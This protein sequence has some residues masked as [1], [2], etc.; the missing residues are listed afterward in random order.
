MFGYVKIVEDELLVRQQKLYKNCYCALCKQIGCYSQFSRLFLS[1]DMTFWALLED[2]VIPDL[3][4]HC[5]G[6]WHR[7]CK[8][9][10]GD[11]KMK[12]CAAISIMLQ[13]QKLNDDVIDGKKSRRIIRRAI[14]KGFLRAK[15]DYPGTEALI[16]AAMEELLGLEKEQCTDFERLETSFCSIFERMLLEAPYSDSY[17]TIKAEI[18]YHV[19][20]WVYLFDMLQD[21]E[22][23][24][25]TGNFNVL[26]IKEETKTRE[27]L[28]ER[29]IMH[30]ERAEALCGVLPYN[31]NTAI[32]TNIITLGLLR[33]MLVAGIDFE[34]ETSL[35]KTCETD[36][37]RKM[38]EKRRIDGEKL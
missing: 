19:S 30:L 29:L 36:L 28:I 33:Q 37:T 3:N 25:K 5:R 26:L 17:M 14:R 21:V 18:S 15:K 16:A 12:Y 2:P 10:A 9:C 27:E 4:K 6:K 22:E 13:Y 38:I 32:L 1:Y 34:H 24:R 11:E 8:K 23:D 20:A 31:D 7:R 35:S